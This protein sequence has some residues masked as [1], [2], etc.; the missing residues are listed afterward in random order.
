V[1]GG[2]LVPGTV[3]LTNNLF[4]L[5]GVKTWFRLIDPAF[6]TS[7][8]IVASYSGPGDSAY[9]DLGFSNIEGRVPSDFDLAKAYSP[10]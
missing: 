5:H 7:N 6:V 3:R 2:E 4:I 8:N 9:V 1:E 10:R